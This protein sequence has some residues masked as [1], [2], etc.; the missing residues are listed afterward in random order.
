[1]YR[2]MGMA[3]CVVALAVPVAGAELPVRLTVAETGGV[4][5]P[6]WPVTSGVP[7]PRGAVKDVR[8]LALKDT[9]GTPVPCQV[10]AVTRWPDGS[11][12]WVEVNFQTDLPT[13][14]PATAEAHETILHVGSYWRVFAMCR[15]AVV[16]VEVLK[17]VAPDASA[18]RPLRGQRG[19]TSEI[20]HIATAPPP[21]DWMQP[22]FDDDAWFRSPGPVA[23]RSRA[24]G[25]YRGIRALLCIRGKCTVTDAGTVKRLTLSVGYRGGVVVY[26]T[27]REVARKDLPAGPI[28][29][30]TPGT[31]YPK[32]AYVDAGGRLIGRKLPK[33]LK[34][35]AD[36]RRSRTLGP[37]SL[38]T[39]LLKTGVNVLALEIHRSD[40]RPEA[41][42]PGWNKGDE[43][44]WSH[45]ELS[46]LRLA[47][48]GG[49]ILPNLSRPKGVQV[50]N[51]DAH[52]VFGTSEY[53]DPNEGLRPIRLVGVRNGS[54][55]GQVVVG[56]TS[57]LEAVKATVT[58]L[59]QPDGVG[60]IPAS[61]V[62]VRYAALSALAVPA[63]QSGLTARLRA[64]TPAFMALESDPP[65][66]VEPA[67]GGAVQPVWVT[68]H[69]PREA[70]AGAY[71]GVLTL[72]ARR[73]A[74][75]RVPIELEVIDWTLPDARDF[76]TFIGIYQSPESVAL[77]Y[78]V[79]M[80]S[81]AHWA[82]LEKSFELLGEL[83]NN[84]LIVPLVNRTQ[85]GNDE[86]MVPWLRQHDGSYTY[87][88]TVHDRYLALAR[89]YCGLK[90]ISYQV[91]TPYGGGY[92]LPH[93]LPTKPTFVTVADAAR[94]TREAMQ[95]PAFGT[96]EGRR[97]W[98]PLL[99]A[100][101]ARL[102]REGLE[103]A[104]LLGIHSDSFTTHEVT[105]QF[106]GILPAAGWHRAAHG[107]GHARTKWARYD[108]R[109]Y[110]YVPNA[111]PAPGRQRRHGWATTPPVTMSQ[112]LY[113][114]WQPPRM[115]RTMAERALLLG[116]SGAGRMCLDY[117]PVKGSTNLGSLFNRWPDS[118]AC[119]RRPFLRYLS[120]PGRAG[121][122]ATIKTEAMREGLQEAEARIFIEQTLVKKRIT[123]PLA[124]RCQRLLDERA[125]FCRMVHSSAG[126]GKTAPL[127]VTY[128]AGWQQRSADLY[129][130]AAEVAGR[131]AE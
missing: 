6:N 73:L 103:R 20:G 13:A 5:R 30:A 38:P 61:N 69:V 41:L 54:Y 32:A 128:G 59:K 53:G 37:V 4:V 114:Q 44:S 107:R 112:R 88:F 104:L 11:L 23:G 75:V 120:L 124:E 87:D 21:T 24:W 42:R 116:D 68:V 84:L 52:R 86:C 56:S 101:R 29:P 109:E 45:I 40:F 98:T 89:K 43:T 10:D 72:A 123:G 51:Q 67:S 99:H 106:K 115:M 70:P 100:V 27:G 122:V 36:R 74:D 92:H 121:A 81:E 35:A 93:R 126:Y 58:D 80:W 79:P 65:A 83:G 62:E 111:I 105:E 119:Q 57:A 7:L 78:N 108:Y 28:W 77:Q 96:D 130:L 25:I 102:T 82:R 131:L 127:R 8:A 129:R 85:F 76:R 31:L 46:A 26:L 90:V 17:E 50:F 60:T 3:V 2:L 1:M 95:L 64:Q 117:W 66:K 113:D 71:R 19:P 16:P 15:D 14:A 125:D 12:K 49:G 47:A 55:S 9:A 22:D 91:W 63:V 18:P 118:S 94:G 39:R 34:E 110:L 33:P 48:D 97:L